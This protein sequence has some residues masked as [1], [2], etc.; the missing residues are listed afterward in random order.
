MEI[1]IAEN[2]SLI[3][4][5]LKEVKFPKGCLIGAIMRNNEIIIPRGDDCLLAKDRVVVFV[6]HDIAK[7]VLS[8]F[9]DRG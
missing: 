4:V 1:M 2:S 8:L 6:L 9:K 5:P 7:K 3:G